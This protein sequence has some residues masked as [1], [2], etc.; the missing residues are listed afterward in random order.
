MKILR[1]SL[2]VLCIL[3][4][5]GTRHDGTHKEAKQ[6]W[7]ISS[8]S[9]SASYAGSS[10]IMPTSA[11]LKMSYFMRVSSVELFRQNLFLLHESSVWLDFLLE[12][13]LKYTFSIY[14]FVLV[15]YLGRNLGLFFFCFILNWLYIALQIRNLSHIHLTHFFL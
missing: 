6:F 9:G 1:C 5:S 4:L 12:Y 7:F 3:N 13:I 10:C 2:T 8:Y 15:W 14:Q 11:V